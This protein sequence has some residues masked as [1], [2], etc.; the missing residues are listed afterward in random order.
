MPEIVAAVEFTFGN[1]KIT[2]SIDD[3]EFS[4]K[5]FFVPNYFG[6]FFMRHFVC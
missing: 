1:E 3:T 2:N 6:T 5:K 4:K